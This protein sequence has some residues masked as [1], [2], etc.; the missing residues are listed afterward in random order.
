[1]AHFHMSTDGTNSKTPSTSQCLCRVACS[2]HASSVQV[3]QAFEN[4][5]ILHPSPPAIQGS[6]PMEAM[7]MATSSTHTVNNV[8]HVLGPIPTISSFE[9]LTLVSMV[10]NSETYTVLQLSPSPSPPYTAFD[11]ILPEPT[12]FCDPMNMSIDQYPT[13]TSCNSNWTSIFA[14]IKRLALLWREPQQLFECQASM[15]SLG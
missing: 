5:P 6:A 7:H 4:Q 14:M 2:L 13:F 9:T 12:A 1:M 15:A 11:M 8:V 3:T 10:H